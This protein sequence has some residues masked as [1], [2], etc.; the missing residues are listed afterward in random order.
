MALF[1]TP[2]R[3]IDEARLLSLVEASTPEG[4]Q[5]DYR[6]TLP[7]RGERDHRDFLED[8][9]S[10][11]N[12]A[13]GDIVYG[14]AERRDENNRTTGEP[15]ASVGVSESTNINEERLRLSQL[16]RDAVDPPLTRFQLEP[17]ERP[18]Q[19]PCLILRVFRSWSGLHMITFRNTTQR[20]YTRGPNGK[21]PMDVTAIRDGFLQAATRR[22]RIETFRRERVARI[23]ANE[24]SVLLDDGMR[25]ILHVVPLDYHEDAWTRF[26][27][28]T[29]NDVLNIL[30]PF[31][32]SIQHLRF[33]LDGYLV[34]A[35]HGRA[36]T[37]L[38]RDG[39]IEAVI[40][41]GPDDSERVYIS[42][43]QIEEWLIDGLDRVKTVY[44]RID[45]G[46]PF[47]IGVTLALVR[48]AYLVPNYQGGR[49]QTRQLPAINEDV[50]L[51]ALDEV[52]DIR[53]PAESLLAKSIETVWNMGGFGSSPYYKDGHWIRDR[54][55]R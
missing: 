25:V 44:D 34:T 38:F 50:G 48:G 37:Q 27:Q 55:Q 19:T 28:L 51:V 15:A 30:R 4:R 53:E 29:D 7:G 12:A 24:G 2:I 13:G 54:R 9:T 47:A 40:A 39:T 5:I 10:F 1:N 22:E 11:A 8:A 20:F 49:W 43:H 33:N 35:M 46:G 17:I 31:D 23:I 26:R 6:E 16:L 42:G 32:G 52:N 18:G 3:Q 14:I 36:Y 45:V 41:P 21:V